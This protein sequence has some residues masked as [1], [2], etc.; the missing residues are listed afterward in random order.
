MGMAIKLLAQKH[1]LIS[2]LDKIKFKKNDELANAFS[3]V[4]NLT[5]LLTIIWLPLCWFTDQ[6]ILVSN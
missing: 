1:Q 6:K 2:A 3:K 5:S 4:F